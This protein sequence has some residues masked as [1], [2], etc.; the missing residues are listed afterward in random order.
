MFLGGGISFWP[1]VRVNSSTPLVINNER[2]LTSMSSCFI[3]WIEPPLNTLLHPT[4]KKSIHF[5]ACTLTKIIIE[6]IRRISLL[7]RRLLDEWTRNTKHVRDTYRS[8]KWFF[9]FISK[10]KTPE[11]H[12]IGIL[13]GYSKF[14]LSVCEEHTKCRHVDSPSM[15]FVP[16]QPKKWKNLYVTSK[17][18]CLKSSCL[19]REF[20]EG[21]QN[22]KDY[23]IFNFLSLCGLFILHIRAIIRPILK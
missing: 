11:A 15:F 21:E 7:H 2:S 23:L 6:S 17:A 1:A 18:D 19:V 16:T 3:N 9:L 10:G 5:V 13:L 20:S 22:K 12:Y 8:I 14:F 4:P